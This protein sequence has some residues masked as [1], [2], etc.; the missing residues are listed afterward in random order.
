M[1]DASAVGASTPTL[2]LP[3]RGRGFP[4]QTLSFALPPPLGEGRG[5]GL[6]KLA[7]LTLDM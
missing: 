2:A 1:S 7:L 4:V 3:R 6:L 5:R